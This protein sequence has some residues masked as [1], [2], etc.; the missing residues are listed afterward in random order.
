MSPFG[1]KYQLP[2][3][4]TLILENSLIQVYYNNLNFVIVRSKRK[5]LNLRL[6]NFLDNRSLHRCPLLW[7]ET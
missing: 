7:I 5:L 3:N 4:R 2:S 6:V 1:Y